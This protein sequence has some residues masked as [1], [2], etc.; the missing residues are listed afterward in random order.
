MQGEVTLNTVQDRT[1]RTIKRKGKLNSNMSRM[2]ISFGDEALS[3]P[4]SKEP[5][6]RD[7][8]ARAT[9]KSVICLRMV[10][11]EYVEYLG[12]TAKQLFMEIDKD[13]DEKISI[14]EIKEALKNLSESEELEQQAGAILQRMDDDHDKKISLDE[15]KAN[16][17][18]P[19]VHGNSAESKP[20][21]GNDLE[22]RGV[23]EAI[24][25]PSAVATRSRGCCAAP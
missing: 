5:P 22:H 17:S 2:G 25:P 10:R 16:F 23:K 15:F 12:A 14:G 24:P 20:S 8:T 3:S 13:G 21:D 7:E 9:S 4:E 18:P 6:K 11:A 19:R 1:G